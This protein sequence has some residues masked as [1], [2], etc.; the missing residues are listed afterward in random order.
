MNS[1][2]EIKEAENISKNIYLKIL[3]KYFEFFLVIFLFFIPS[4]LEIFNY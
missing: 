4:Q 1:F 3:D 2:Y